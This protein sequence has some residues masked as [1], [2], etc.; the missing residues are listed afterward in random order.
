MILLS[1]KY[2]KNRKEWILTFDNGES[3][4]VNDDIKVK[5]TIYPQMDISQ[6]RYNTLKTEAEHVLAYEKAIELLSY[7]EHSSSE[8][9]TKLLQKGFAPSVGD[10]VIKKMI[11]KGYLDD[12]RFA[13]L[14]FRELMRHGKYG[15]LMIR[16][17][18]LEKGIK[19]ELIDKKI[20]SIS[21]KEWEQYASGL[22]NKKM[23]KI[24]NRDEG[25]REILLRYLMNKGFDYSSI[26]SL[27]KVAV[28]NDEN[29]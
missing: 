13:N 11:S 3:L 14:Y 28:E 10:T 26:E 4:T 12:E 7:R 1:L 25:K 2:R 15:P 6:E 21:A 16:K 8:L 19:P 29:T 22:L 20:G 27:V 9:R 18:M 24:R 5:Y 17:K 23:Q